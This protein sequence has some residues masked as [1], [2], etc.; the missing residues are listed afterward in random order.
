MRLPDVDVYRLVEPQPEACWVG[1]HGGSHVE[2]LHRVDGRVGSVDVH[3]D[4]RRQRLPVELRLRML[5]S[6]VVGSW[7]LDDSASLSLPMNWTIR[8]SDRMIVV[9][10]TPTKFIGAQ[11]EV[12]DGWVG[13]ARLNERAVVAIKSFGSPVAAIERRDVNDI[14]RTPP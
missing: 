3:W 6:N 4:R 14:P 12:V 1:G 13:V 8:Q 7:L 2:V 5:L 10:G 9:D 11:I